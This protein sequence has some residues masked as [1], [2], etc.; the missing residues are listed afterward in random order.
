[1]NYN[2]FIGI[3]VSKKTLDFAVFKGKELLFKWVGEN[4]ES[5]IKKFWLQLKLQQGFCI[6]EAMFCMEHTGIYNQHLLSFLYS[7]KAAICVEAAVHIKLSSGL[8]RGKSDQIDAVRIAQYAYKNCMELRLWQPKRQVIQQL[9]HLS[10]LRN[11][12][13]NARKQLTV[14]LNETGGFD[15]NAADEC[16]KL[17]KASLKALDEDIKRVELKMEQVIASDVELKRLFLVVTSVQGI[18][19]VT[20]TEIIITTNEFKDITDPAKFACYSGVA[21][22][23]HS[24]GTSIKGKTRVSHKANKNMKS[25]LHM[26]AL[27]AIN[28]NNDLKAYYQRKIEQ[29]KNKMLVIN[30]V[31]NKLIWRIFAC[32]RNNRP[33]QKNYQLGLV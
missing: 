25:L 6:N 12:V 31:R 2:F 4:D 20:A 26:A 10:G 27:V 19:K 21:P 7:K 14:A 3:D 17:C 8:Q 9:K 5:G 23:E 33:Y 32:V 16:K 15:R 13:I 22:F 28:Y 18:G 1:M 11:R 29:K 30:A 24:S